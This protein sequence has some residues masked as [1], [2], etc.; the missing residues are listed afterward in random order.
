VLLSL[1]RA[2]CFGAPCHLVSGVCCSFLHLLRLMDLAASLDVEQDALLWDEI[3]PTASLDQCERSQ[4]PHN[5]DSTLPPT[6]V[7]I[8]FSFFVSSFWLSLHP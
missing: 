1:R 2:V 5:M 7:W 3:L 6:D 8:A 4:N